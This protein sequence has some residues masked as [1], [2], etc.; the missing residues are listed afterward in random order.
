MSFTRQ[1]NNYIW[2]PESDRIGHGATST[3]YQCRD[4]VTMYFLTFV[5]FPF[6]RLA[7][8]SINR[9][10]AIRITPTQSKYGELINLDN[11]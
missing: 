11:N 8:S 7:S 10:E 2:S 5:L 4:K 1:T 9:V 6:S 3:V